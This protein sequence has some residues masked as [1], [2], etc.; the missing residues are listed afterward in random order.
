LVAGCGSSSKPT[1]K[2]LTSI[3]TATT[4]S[5][6]PASPRLAFAKGPGPLGYVDNGIVRTQGTGTILLED[7]IKDSVVPHEAL[8]NLSGRHP[9]GGLPAS[10]QGTHHHAQSARDH[11]VRAS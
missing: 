7:G 4:P 3:S 9:P 11:S 2:A 8:E 10:Y 1:P 5:A 6:A